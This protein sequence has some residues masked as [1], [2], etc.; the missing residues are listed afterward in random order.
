MAGVA[1]DRRRKKAMG[2]ACRCATSP[3]VPTATATVSRVFSDATHPVRESTRQAVL[4]AAAE[5]GFEPN[6]LARSL[7][8]SRSQA[9][10]VIVHDISD[11]YFGDIVRGLEDELSRADYRLRE[12]GPRRGE[13]GVLP[14][15]PHGPAGGWHRPGGEQHRDR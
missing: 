8:T 3:S 7:V 15:R 2:R 1:L 5:L 13:G 6:R 12:H 10:G 11:S 4:E 9:I 14:A